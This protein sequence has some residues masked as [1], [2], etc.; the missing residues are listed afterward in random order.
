[1]PPKEALLSVLRY[2]AQTGKLF[3]LHRHP[4]TFNDGKH[5]SERICERW[6]STYA[7]KEAMCIRHSEGY[8]CGVVFH[9]RYLA[10]RIIWRMCTGDSPEEIDHIDGDRVNNRIDNLRACTRQE[11]MRNLSVKSDN[12]SGVTGVGRNKRNGK[13]RV[14]I[15][16]NGKET[17]YGEFVSFE[18]AVEARKQI[19]GMFGYHRNHGKRGN[20]S[21]T[22][23]RAA[24]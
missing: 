17:S 18:D 22:G 9:K 6:N 5:S 20:C 3:W 12:K 11:N 7:G 23:A 24:K 1:M 21:V 10:H 14:R 2:D 19:S 8:Y 4:S 15:Y 13:W 16:Q